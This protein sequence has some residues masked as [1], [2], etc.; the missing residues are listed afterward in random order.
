MTTCAA[1][2]TKRFKRDNFQRTTHIHLIKLQCI[3]KLIELPV[4]SDL[5]ELDIMLLESM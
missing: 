4:L 5:L 3:E 2:K 1:K